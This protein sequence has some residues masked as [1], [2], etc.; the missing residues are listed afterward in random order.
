MEFWNGLFLT[1]GIILGILSGLCMAIHMF[2][3][4][5]IYKKRRN[6]QINVNSRGNFDAFL[7]WWVTIS[8]IIPYFPF[9]ITDLSKFSLM[10]LLIS[11]MIGFF[12]TALAYIL[13]NIGVKNDKG[14]NI[15]ILSYLEPVVATINTAIF[16]RNLSIFTIIGGSLI[17]LTNIL[18]LK[19][20]K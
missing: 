19:F 15:I 9:G 6:V 17:I 1:N 20:S 10:D 16:L 8:L 13:Y 5:K 18:I 11:L 12:P 7:S 3:A 2:A 4:K 14:G